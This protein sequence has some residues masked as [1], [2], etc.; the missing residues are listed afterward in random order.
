MATLCEYIK[1]E[2][3]KKEAKARK[4]AERKEAER[5]AMEEKEARERKAKKK[6]E[7]AR[8]E[9]ERV[10]AIRKD[11]DLHVKLTVKEALS[12]ACAKFREAIVAAKLHEK[13]K[14]KKKLN[15]VPEEEFSE[16]EFV[17]S[18][19]EEIYERP[20]GLS[21]NE[22]RKRGPEL[23]FEDSPPMELPAKR[24]PKRTPWRGI[25]KL[26]VKAVQQEFEDCYPNNMCLKRTDDGS[27]SFDFLGCRVHVGST[28]P[29]AGCVQMSKNE[30][31]RISRN[32]SIRM[33]ALRE[34]GSGYGEGWICKVKK[35]GGNALKRHR[36][37]C[38][39][40][41]SGTPYLYCATL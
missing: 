38:R 37:W 30:V 7:K 29:Y 41:A 35:V 2:C 10:A 26:E 11:I 14:G 40:A 31:E 32:A 6:A 13:M 3:A 16:Y 18:D 33:L 36:G 17:G 19:T 5:R 39:N 1:A 9:E 28:Y 24:T 4:K 23:V 8:E 27:G 20:Q 15:Y 21:I 34:N 22:K 25:L 12:G